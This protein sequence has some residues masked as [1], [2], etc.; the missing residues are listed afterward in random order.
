MKYLLWFVIIVVG[1]FL[2][3]GFVTMPPSYRNPNPIA[4]ETDQVRLD[5]AKDGVR[6]THADYHREVSSNTLMKV[7]FT[8]TNESTESVKDIEVTCF[9]YAKSDTLLGRSVSTIYE[10]LEAKS[11]LSVERFNM[12][13]VHDQTNRVGCQISDL[14]L[15]RTMFNR[16]SIAKN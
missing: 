12:G 2:T 1:G 14:A 6:L 3:I 11:S 7:D 8:F 4:Y 13:V 9:L 16:P 5:R 10:R 15:M